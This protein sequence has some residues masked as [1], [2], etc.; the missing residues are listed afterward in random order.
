MALGAIQALEEAGKK[1]GVDVKVVS[2]D[3][4]KA[5][6]QAMVEGKANVTVECSPLLGPQFY[7]AALAVVQGKTIDRWIKS[8]EGIFRQATAAQDITSR[9]Y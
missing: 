3:G 9:V 4:E 6:F 8:Q 2:I 1:P 5:I 7:E